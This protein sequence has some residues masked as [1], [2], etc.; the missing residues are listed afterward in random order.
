M[1]VSKT[2][3]DE[4][5]YEE[6]MKLI[7]SIV[8]QSD[9]HNYKWREKI[10]LEVLGIIDNRGNKIH[11]ADSDSH[12]LKSGKISL[13]AKGEYRIT[14]STTLGTFGRVDKDN[15]F[16]KK[17]TLCT[18]FNDGGEKVLCV[19]IFYDKQFEEMYLSEQVVKRKIMENNKQVRDSVNINF[20]LIKKYNLNYQIL[21]KKENV[22]S[23]NVF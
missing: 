10:Q 15:T 17:E 2:K 18:L 5:T 23:D 13:N 6:K 9:F 16:D 8:P 21:C 11:G 20:S 14:N 1:E 19:M 12:S 22:K 7:F 3:V 4:L